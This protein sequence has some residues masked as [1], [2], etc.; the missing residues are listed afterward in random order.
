[1][2]Y[3]LKLKVPIVL[4]MCVGL[5]Q[6]A[7]AQ[8]SASKLNCDLTYKAIMEQNK[9]DKLEWV[10]RWFI[11][12][13]KSPVK[14]WIEGWKTEPL[15]SWV[16]IEHPNFHAAERTTLWLART[17]SRAVYWESVQSDDYSVKE[18]DKRTQRTDITLEMY[19]KFFQ[20][21]S[22]WD[23]AKVLTPQHPTDGFSPEFWGF[24]SVS[25][26]N[27]P[28]KQVLLGMDDFMK[29]PDKKC[30]PGPERLGRVMTALLP[31][32]EIEEGSK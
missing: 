10:Q 16:L 21:V 31:I 15:V 4:L 30:E 18:I 19:D 8:T 7:G 1:M 20:T 2:N 25:S 23:Q 32:L 11:T 13:N 9:V 27:S 28:C 6:L 24:L 29:C 3:L 12:Y 5:H 26:T 22:A 17:K 14:K